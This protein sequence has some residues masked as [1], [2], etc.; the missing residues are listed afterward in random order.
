VAL[1]GAAVLGFVLYTQWTYERDRRDLDRARAPLVR[2]PVEEFTPDRDRAI[3]VVVPADT[4]WHRIVG[5]LGEPLF[6]IAVATDLNTIHP[7]VFSATDA[8][9]AAHADRGRKPVELKQTHQFP[10]GY[11]SDS[12]TAYS[13]AASSGDR[14]DLT[15]HITPSGLPKGALVMVLPL[16]NPLEFWDWGDGMSIGQAV[17]EHTSPLVMVLGVALIFVGVIVS[18]KGR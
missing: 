2:I 17:F 8:R 9:L 3:T 16:W 1:G 13:F 4:Q 18:L 15:V 10:F 14:I 5:R 12:Q 7:Q 6:V 11:S